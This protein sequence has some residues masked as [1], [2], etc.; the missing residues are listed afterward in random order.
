MQIFLRVAGSLGILI[1]I[2]WWYVSPDFDPLFNF[3][4]SLTAFVSSFL[5]PKPE[6]QKE[7]LD[8]RHR[9]IMINHAENFWVKG[10][11]EKSLHGAVLLELG[12]R[13]DQSAVNYPWTIK[14]AGTDEILPMQKSML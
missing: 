5:I 1:T 8:Q 10:V 9:H 7:S 2:I 14:T 4:A 13:E 3:V 6:T 11:L 12:I